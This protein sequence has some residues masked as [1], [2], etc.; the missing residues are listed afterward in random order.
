[1]RV[2]TIVVLASL[3]V[4]VWCGAARAQA[5]GETVPDPFPTPAAADKDG[6]TATLTA[7]AATGTGYALVALASSHH[8]SLAAVGDLGAA[9]AIIGPSAGHLYAGEYA[10]VAAMSALRSLA[11]TVIAVGAIDAF[12]GDL[13]CAD[14]GAPAP[15]EDGSCGAN[16]SNHGTAIALVG[17][18]GFVVATAYD[19]WDAHRAAER[20]NAKRGSIAVLPTG[21]GFAVAGRF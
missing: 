1:M 10:H 2:S 18:S 9:L 16:N 19:L 15:G 17:V 21:T 4:A 12:S 14:A 6:T 3:L 20:S 13:E 7:L 11:L 5:P 8:G